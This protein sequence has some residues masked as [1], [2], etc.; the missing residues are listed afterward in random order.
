MK[1][2]YVFNSIDTSKLITTKVNT[3]NDTIKN[4]KHKKI[5]K[6]YK[7]KRKQREYSNRCPR[8]YNVYIKSRFWV[9][10]KNKYF[11]DFGRKCFIC[12]SSK[13]P[14]IHHLEYDNN[15]FGKEKDSMLVCLCFGCHNEF[16]AR[17]GVKQKMYHEFND[18]IDLKKGQ[19][20]L[21]C[22]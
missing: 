21:N 8:K 4:S 7:Q 6:K 11:K 19:E 10:R 18:F 20:Q 22:I 13:F 2:N 16:H 5:K 1:H 15:Y 17:Y 12:S 9:A 14:T 3:I